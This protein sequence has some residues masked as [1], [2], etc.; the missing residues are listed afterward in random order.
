MTTTNKI[1]IVIAAFLFTVGVYDAYLYF[2]DQRIIEE[3]YND[4]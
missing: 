3:T 4:K 1:G 2:N